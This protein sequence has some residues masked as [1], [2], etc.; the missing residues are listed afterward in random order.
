MF[1]WLGERFGK[2]K[3]KTEQLRE[4]EVDDSVEQGNAPQQAPS[5][6]LRSLFKKAIADAEQIV[7]SIKVRAQTEAEAEATK[8]ITQ[9]ELEAQEIKG[10]AKITA[11]KEAE[12]ILSAASREAEI[13]EVEAKQEALQSLT[14][15]G[16]EVEKEI[17]EEYKRAYSRLSSFLQDLVK[18]GQ[19]VEIELRDKTAKLLESESL[20]L[21]EYE[22]AEAAVPPSATPAPTET[23]LTA[24][25]APEEKVEEPVQLQEEAIEEKVEEPA[26]L[27]EEAIEEKV[28][29]PVQLQEEAI[30][31]KV[32][33]PVQLQEEAIEEKVEEPAQLQEEAIVSEQ[34]GESAPLKLDSQALYAG[35]VELIIASSVELKLVSRL[36]NYLQTVPELRIL[37]TRGSWD[38]GTTITVVLEKP[39]SL[40]NIMS[41]APGIEVTPELLEKGGLAGGK[42]SSP[43]RGGEKRAGRIK[44]NL[45]EA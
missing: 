1:E 25:T 5:D 16:E 30:E 39:M 21:K 43:L 2:S 18:E 17:G 12:G 20:E 36:Y 26:Q 19:N 7:A 34:E 31:E 15:V 32:E 42:S 27:Q 11:Q 9:A 33:E 3:R 28:E 4:R 8:I 44:L 38:Q 24:D 10:E 40:V 13:A 29:E 37:Y 22:A 6:S 45:Q 41:E 35:E 14:M 23:E